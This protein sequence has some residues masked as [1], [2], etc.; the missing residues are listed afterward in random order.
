M[1]RANIHLLTAFAYAAG[2]GCILYAYGK[3]GHRGLLGIAV[4]WA[5]LMTLSVVQAI[6][7]TQRAKRP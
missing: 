1:R 6:A 5:V 7:A 3:S 2:I 4:V